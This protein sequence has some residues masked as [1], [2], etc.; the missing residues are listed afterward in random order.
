M[1]IQ[2]THDPQQRY[3]CR[4]EHAAGA[5]LAGNPELTWLLTQLTA[6]TKSDRAL[7]EDHEFRERFRFEGFM[8]SVCRQQSQKQIPLWTALGS[9]DAV[10]S[11]CGQHGLWVSS[12][13]HDGHS[14]TG[15]GL[16][17]CRGQMTV[18][19]DFA[20]AIVMTETTKKKEND[21]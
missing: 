19:V 2:R 5:Q 6:N 17:E 8:S 9:V 15:I 1:H 14:A 21:N 11:Q 7:S 18:G 20:A 4:Y 13:T 3:H 16:C 12:R 10:R